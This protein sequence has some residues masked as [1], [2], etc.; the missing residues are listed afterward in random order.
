MERTR[1]R[2]IKIDIYIN[3]KSRT[4]PMLLNKVISI[5]IQTIMQCDAAGSALLFKSVHA[6]RKEA[7]RETC[8]PPL[9]RPSASTTC[10]ATNA[11]RTPQTPYSKA[12]LQPYTRTTCAA[13][14]PGSPPRLHNSNRPHSNLN[15]KQIKTSAVEDQVTRVCI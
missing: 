11:L 5:Q 14:H 15:N 8:P 9:S 4:K 1:G 7:T 2:D 6:R 10:N 3:I 12:F 13:Q